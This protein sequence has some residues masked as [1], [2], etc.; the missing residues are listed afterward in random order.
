MAPIKH[1]HAGQSLIENDKSKI[2]GLTIGK[3]ENLQP[4][5]YIPRG[6]KKPIYP[7]AIEFSTN[8]EQQKSTEAQDFPKIFFSGADPARTYMVVCLDIDAP[9]AAFNFLSPILHWMQSDVKVTSDGVLKYD[10]PFIAD[11]IGPG[12]PPVGAPHRY[13]FFLYEQPAGFDLTAHAPADG[14]KMARMSRMRYDFESWAEMVKLGP[15]V[16]FNYF[17]CN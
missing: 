2:L 12:P 8:A 6:G 16:A 17:T 14:Q 5:T 4:G 10:A 15:L 1:F 11:Y 9:F 7:A 3:H 13:L